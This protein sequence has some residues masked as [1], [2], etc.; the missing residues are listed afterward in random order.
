MGG[1]EWKGTQEGRGK[2]RVVFMVIEEK[3]RGSA[4]S[5]QAATS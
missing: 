1:K 2:G 4:F 5:D 3:Q